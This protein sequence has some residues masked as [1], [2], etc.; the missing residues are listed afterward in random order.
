MMQLSKPGKHLK[1]GQEVSVIL[2]IIIIVIT[3]TVTIAITNIFLST[4]AQCLAM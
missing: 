3:I 1:A 2:V 4:T